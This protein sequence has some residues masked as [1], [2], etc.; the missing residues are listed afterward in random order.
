MRGGQSDAR[1]RGSRW[2]SSPI[3]PLS[4][5]QASAQRRQKRLRTSRNGCFSAAGHNRGDRACS[6]AVESADSQAKTEHGGGNEWQ[7]ASEHET[8]ARL[9]E[10]PRTKAGYAEGQPSGEDGVGGEQATL[11]RAPEVG[12]KTS[13]LRAAADLPYRSIAVA[14]LARHPMPDRPLHI[15]KACGAS[16]FEADEI[17]GDRPD[18]AFRKLRKLGLDITHSA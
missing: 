6:Q 11:P 12:T 15:A 10:G 4:A 14:G 16:L 7:T 13:A 5:R 9:R 3:L 2:R 8:A 1:L 17:L 18:V